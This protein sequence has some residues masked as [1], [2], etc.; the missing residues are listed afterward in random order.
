MSLVAHTALVRFREQGHASSSLPGPIF[1]QKYI[2]KCTHVH[3]CIFIYTI[4]NL[5]FEHFKAEWSSL[6]PQRTDDTLQHIATLCN[7]LQHTRMIEWVMS[8]IS[9][10][11]LSPYP[12][13]GPDIYFWALPAMFKS[14]TMQLTYTH[15]CGNVLG[16]AMCQNRRREFRNRRREFRVLS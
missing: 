3:M 8:N 4:L 12:L 13:P 2:F 1:A 10:V 14:P 9:Y 11:K 7:T 5:F 6:S 16:D 15:M